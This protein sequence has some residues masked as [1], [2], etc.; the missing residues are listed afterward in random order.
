MNQLKLR[1]AYLDN[2]CIGK[3]S[4]NGLFLCYTVERPWL[5]NRWSISCVP[6]GIYD[7]LPI[8]GHYKYGDCWYLENK[9]LGVSLNDDTQRTEIL[10]HI[11]NFPHEVIGC[12]APGLELH[13]TRWGVAHSRLAMEKLRKIITSEFEWSIEII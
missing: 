2:C 5:S 13:P 9:A 10:I 7:L 1:R 3:L 8:K 12:I 4:L 6:A 11:A